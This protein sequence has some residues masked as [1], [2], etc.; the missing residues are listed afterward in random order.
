MS[1]KRKLQAFLPAA[2]AAAALSGSAHAATY[3]AGDLLIG[4]V[5]GSGQGSDS[6]LVV[7][8]GSA[9]S[10]RDAFD[11]GT[12]ISSIA[13]IG[14]QLTTQFGASWFER[15]DLYVSLFSATN[16]N[17]TTTALI[18]Q[19]PGRTLYVSQPRTDAG[20]TGSASSQGWIVAGNTAMTGA[21]T[22]V[23]ATSNRFAVTGSAGD[24]L[25]IIPDTADNSLDEFVQPTTALSFNTFDGGID[26]SFGTGSWGSL[27]GGS[28][29]AALDLYRIQA[30][31]D[32]PGQYGFGQTALNRT[33]DYT[34]TFT[35]GQDGT[36]S[37]VNA[38]PEPTSTLMIGLASAGILFRRRRSA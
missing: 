1:P 19:D 16:N 18:N 3:T 9:A 34:G 10:Y 35:V 20:S 15:T 30:R 33:G 12:N 29:E 25:A 2:L 26:Q 32:A 37:F 23:Q 21:A 36:I 17:P 24:T 6:T 22:A 4:F 31:S 27:G 28:V 14:S 13:T 5:A 38:V 11:S 8:L 7:N